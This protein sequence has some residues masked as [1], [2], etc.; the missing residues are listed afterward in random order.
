MKEVQ[1]V[2]F[3]RDVKENPFRGM[4]STLALLQS[5]SDTDL[6]MELVEKAYAECD[7]KEKKDLFWSLVFSIGD[8]TARQ[9]NIFKG[10]K[11]DGGGNAN[12]K[13]FARI[14]EWMWENHR[15]QFL[16]FLNAD[17]FEEYTCFDFLLNN[18]IRTDK[19]QTVTE[20]PRLFEDPEYR[21]ALVEHLY[22][23]INGSNTYAKHLVAKFLTMPRLSKRKGHKRMLPETKKAMLNK[24]KLLVELSKEMNWDYKVKDDQFAIFWG[25]REWRKKYNQ[26]LESVLFSTGRI[27]DF[28]KESFM[29]WLEALPSQARFRV[30]NRVLYSKLAPVEEGAE[31]TLKYPNLKQ[32]F[33]EWEASKEAKQQEQR[34]LEEK[35][36]QGQ[37]T[38]QEVVRLEKVK[39][40]AK[41]NVGAVNFTELYKE[42]VSGNVDK[43][44]LE[45]FIN[46]VNLP[47]N[48]LVIVDDSGSM[49]NRGAFNFAKF[50]ASV[51]LVKNPDDDGRNLLGFFGQDCRWY[52][53]IDMKVEEVPNH[54]FRSVKRTRIDAEPFVK[55]HLSFYDNFARIS[56]FCDAAFDNQ[57]RTNIGS[58]IESLYQAC[59]KD[60]NMLDVLQSY[61]LWT[62][63][64][65]YAFNQLRTPAASLRQFLSYCENLL[66]FKP[67]IIMID[68][69][70]APDCG[71]QTRK[72]LAEVE[73][74]I[75][76][77]G[78]VVLIEQFL[79]NFRDME[80]F[81]AYV[82]LQS[83]YRSNRYDIIRQNVIE[84]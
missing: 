77:P 18:R 44:K 58:I 42:V 52:G 62:I 21:K 80:R 12:R 1:K 48:S 47:Y 24:V 11:K 45:S 78:N 7:T 5:V 3:N 26:E 33:E 39:K 36:R 79:T 76:I 51:C 6:D 61:P 50:L 82:A 73:N 38:E 2:T 75:Y 56:N 70:I 10:Q 67:F 63:I 14:V 43:L 35:V 20:A 16:R 41:V 66:G 74:V 72:E 59:Q 23:V 4:S 83:L 54:F 32:W 9:H 17:L 34:V 71:T 53:G 37:A 31:G 29:K 69:V 8:I 84:K 25:Y 22:A 28:D 40:E 68:A 46:K 19:K 27:N 49:S 13:T 15:D 57:N 55:P 64:S 81:D 30:K 65:D 60:P